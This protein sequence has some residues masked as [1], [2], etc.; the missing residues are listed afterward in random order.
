MNVFLRSLSGAMICLIAAIPAAAAEEAASPPPV[1]QQLAGMRRPYEECRWRIPAISSVNSFVLACQ[2]R[3]WAHSGLGLGLEGLYHETSSRANLRSDAMLAG[4]S[5]GAVTLQYWTENSMRVVPLVAGL[6]IAAGVLGT[7]Y[8]VVY[9]D[10]TTTGV[11]SSG[12][13]V[14]GLALYAT[15]PLVSYLMDR[16]VGKGWPHLQVELS[17]M[18]EGLGRLKNDIDYDLNGDGIVDHVKG[19]DFRDPSGKAAKGLLISGFRAGFVWIL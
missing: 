12:G 7:N 15:M 11:A 10:G 4:Y 2:Y 14:A 9:S 19:Q 3:V 17:W 18:L 6:R 1:D 13:L 8:A 5:S 16:P